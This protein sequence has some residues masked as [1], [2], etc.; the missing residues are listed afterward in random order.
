MRFQKIA[1]KVVG[2]K[3]HLFTAYCPAQM[4]KKNWFAVLQQVNL[5]IKRDLLMEPQLMVLNLWHGI[6]LDP[7]LQELVGLLLC[8][9]CSLLL[10]NWK[11]VKILQISDR[12]L[13]VWDF[14]LYDKISVSI[15]HTNKLPVLQN[16]QKKWLPLLEVA[17]SSKINVVFFSN[18]KHIDLLSYFWEMAF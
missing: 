2:I 7:L 6:K 18:R 17:S 14:F 16:Y 9:A 8:A 11:T 5:I 4:S 10:S 15:M 3:V 1:G 13:R 12:Y